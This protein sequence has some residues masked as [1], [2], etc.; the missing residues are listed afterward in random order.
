[1]DRLEQI[2]YKITMINPEI[3]DELLGLLYEYVITRYVNEISENIRSLSTHTESNKIYTSSVKC[4]TTNKLLEEEIFG[5]VT[6]CREA[7]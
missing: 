4:V 5:A 6:N 1:M 3:T 2:K 7:C